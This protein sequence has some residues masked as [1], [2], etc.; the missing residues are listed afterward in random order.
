[1][2]TELAAARLLRDRAAVM[3]D[4]NKDI[5][6]ESSRAKL[7]AVQV[8][9]RVVGNCIQSTGRYG[10]LKDSLFD[11]YLRDVKMLGTAGG[12]LEVMRNN[13]ARSILKG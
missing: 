5:S 8:A 9:D 12:S 6:L 3:D 7:L 1:M 4:Q 13:I 2:S 11:L 10:C